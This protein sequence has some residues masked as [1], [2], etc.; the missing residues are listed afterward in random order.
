VADRER[1]GRPA[2]LADSGGPMIDPREAHRSTPR[3]P[4]PGASRIIDQVT[5]ALGDQKAVAAA[6][7]LVCGGVVIGVM[8]ERVG[9][10]ASVAALVTFV[11]VF[12]VQHTSSRESRALNVKLDELIRVTNARNDL[13]GVEDESHDRLTER[14]ED[15]LEARDTG[16]QQAER[17]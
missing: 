5:D 14:G 16:G 1:S 9:E 17:A 15:L 7:V 3:Q 8:T 6:A 2:G 10:V 13:I 4:R 11:M 12:A